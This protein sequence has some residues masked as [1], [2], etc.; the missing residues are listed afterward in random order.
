MIAVPLGDD[1]PPENVA[2]AE[3]SLQTNG[4]ANDA[5]KFSELLTKE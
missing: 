2:D 3:T 5:F 4:P 1:Q